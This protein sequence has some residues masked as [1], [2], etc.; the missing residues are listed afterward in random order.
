MW[1]KIFLLK[2]IAAWKKIKRRSID[3]KD[4]GFTFVETLA[5][6]AIMALLTAG[7][8]V[9]TMQIMEHARKT[10]AKEEISSYKAALQSYYVDCGN[11]PTSSQGLEA[12]WS[13]PLLMPVPENW[14]GPYLDRQVQ[15]DPWG[16]EYVYM[17]KDNS[18][19]PETAPEGLPF[20]IVS[21]GS[22]GMQGGSGKNAD[23]NSWN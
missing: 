13:K 21:Y 20:V 10:E 15:R 6:L 1:L 3:E 11:F 14:N 8:G 9:S 5:V 19:F 17:N 16:N 22:D 4:S 12:L 23:I 2:K 18:V 7:A